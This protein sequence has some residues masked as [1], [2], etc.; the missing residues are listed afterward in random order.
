MFVFPFLFFFFEA[1][2][3]VL[4]EGL[5]ERFLFF[6]EA[7]LLVCETGFEKVDGFL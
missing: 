6:G 4:Q 3:Q 1:E 5:V 7:G 2:V